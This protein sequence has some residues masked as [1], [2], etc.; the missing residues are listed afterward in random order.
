MSVKSAIHWVI[1]FHIYLKVNWRFGGKFLLHIQCFKS[2]ENRKQANPYS[3]C[4]LHAGSLLFC[5]NMMSKCTSETSG[6]FHQITWRYVPEDIIIHNH[7][8]ENLKWHN[9]QL[10]LI[11]AKA[12]IGNTICCMDMYALS[13]F[14]FFCVFCSNMY[15]NSTASR[16]YCWST[17][18]K[19]KNSIFS[20]VS[21][22]PD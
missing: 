1:T 11:I 15:M 13:N 12:A 21:R 18:I 14:V 9:P 8:C 20:V 2:K 16:Q 4:L 7:R 6:D 19:L 5:L 17:L 3:C 22:S 10:S